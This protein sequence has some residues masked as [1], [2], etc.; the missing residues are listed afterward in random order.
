MSAP[1]IDIATFKELQ[2]S[3]GADFVVELLDAYFEELPQML[4]ELRTAHNSGALEPFRRAAHSIKS[5]SYTFGALTL[6]G[7]AR[8][9]ELGEIPKDAAALDA[10]EAE[11]ARVV[12]ALK[13]LT[14]G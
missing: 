12:A 9:L 4:A 13:E 5:N 10:L 11:Y 14:H 6:G 1:T 7:M 2:D 3:T 8:E